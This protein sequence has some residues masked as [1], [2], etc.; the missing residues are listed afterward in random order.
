MPLLFLTF[1]IAGENQPAEIAQL[2]P[3]PVACPC[4][5][6]QLMRSVCQ[7]SQ[8]EVLTSR[9]RDSELLFIQTF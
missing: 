9:I 4:T 7:P 2:T 8:T 6:S 1:G 3:A 5:E